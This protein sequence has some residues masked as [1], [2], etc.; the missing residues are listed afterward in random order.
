M[1]SWHFEI[2][3][4]IFT[5]VKSGF[6]E[7][8]CAPCVIN[9]KVAGQCGRCQMVGVDQ[10]TGTKTKEPLMSLS[11]YRG[12]KVGQT[13]FLSNVMFVP[14]CLCMK[15]AITLLFCEFLGDF[16]CVSDPSATKG[17]PLCWLP[18]TPWATHF[19][20]SSSASTASLIYFGDI[21]GP[22][23]SRPRSHVLHC[24]DF[25]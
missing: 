8:E 15:G 12:G 16:W 25:L 19:V 9:P 14:V 18:H 23:H 21:L 7:T 13:H 20:K 11:A 1:V 3:V 17:F 2:N 22:H 10:E 4:E 5:C 24:E 6:F